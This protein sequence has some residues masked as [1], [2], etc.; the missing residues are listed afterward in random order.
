MT[1]K[2]DNV[3][4]FMQTGCGRCELGA[5]DACKV[6]QWREI[7]V[8]LR[9]VLLQS[10]LNEEIKWH[11]PCYTYQGGNVLMLS[12]LK[13]AAVVSFFKG[14]LLDDPKSLL[15]SPGENSRHARYFKFDSLEQVEQYQ[16]DLLSFVAQAI[17]LQRRGA[18]VPKTPANDPVPEELTDRF[19]V[20]EEYQQAFANLT[21]GRQRSYLL[22]FNSAKQSKTKLA[23]IEKCRDKVLSGKGWNEL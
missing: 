4:Q 19:D 15:Q 11:C 14:V 22:H 8:A 17:E 18:Q 1:V 12:A 5:T 21:P 7:L 9:E 6:N 13:Q 3:D 20:D 10:E 16:K 23:R 2:P